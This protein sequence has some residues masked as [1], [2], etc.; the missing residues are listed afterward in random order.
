MKTASMPAINSNLSKEQEYSLMALGNMYELLSKYTQKHLNVLAFPVCFGKLCD[1]TQR[2]DFKEWWEKY[3]YSNRFT[4]LGDEGERLINANLFGMPIPSYFLSDTAEQ[5]NVVSFF[6]LLGNLAEVAESIT[7]K[8]LDSVLEEKGFP[9]IGSAILNAK[10]FFD[11]VP[12]PSI[13]LSQD[14]SQYVDFLREYCNSDHRATRYVKALD[15]RLPNLFS[16][17]A[18]LE[19][20]YR[21]ILSEIYG[22]LP[23]NSKIFAVKNT[24]LAEHGWYR[25]QYLSD[26]L[27][28]KG[29]AVLLDYMKLEH[30]LESLYYYPDF[31]MIRRDFP[32]QTHNE[33]LLSLLDLMTE[34]A[35]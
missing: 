34:L 6:D 31:E 10:R 9:P 13:H 22:A 33:S 4:Y 23:A 2:R 27:K 11:T 21:R 29:Q 17:D 26:E 3:Q 15:K 19:N 8:A 1:L 18:L 5:Y 20:G 24:E 14:T 16:D 12:L 25:K 30:S 32:N 7:F 35:L 28:E